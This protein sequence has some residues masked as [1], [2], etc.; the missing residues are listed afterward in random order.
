MHSQIENTLTSVTS[1]KPDA[2]RLLITWGHIH[3]CVHIYM[4]INTYSVVSHMHAHVHIH[5]HRNPLPAWKAIN[6]V[7]K[8][9]HYCMALECVLRRVTSLAP[10]TSLH[11]LLKQAQCNNRSRRPQTGFNYRSHLCTQNIQN[12]QYF[13]A[14]RTILTSFTSHLKSA[15]NTTSHTLP[16]NFVLWMLRTGPET[17]TRSNH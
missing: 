9:C 17:A 7:L 5:A 14:S 13:Q 11:S 2:A 12:V 4:S 15:S 16:W 10:H 8:N 1:E 6:L 3:E